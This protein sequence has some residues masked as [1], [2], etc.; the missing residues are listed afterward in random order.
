MRLNMVGPAGHASGFWNP[1]FPH[2]LV[3]GLPAGLRMCGMRAWVGG[4]GRYAMAVWGVA[5]SFAVQGA[6]RPQSDLC[7]VQG[8]V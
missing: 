8:K 6:D 4:W 1:L 3:A 2:D 5:V 7:A